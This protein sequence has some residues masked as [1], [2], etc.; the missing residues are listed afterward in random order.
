MLAE[1]FN[2]K[3]RRC[4]E[5]LESEVVREWLEGYPESTKISYLTNL[6]IFLE[7]AKLTPEKLRPVLDD[8]KLNLIENDV[9]VP[10]ADFICEEM[11]KRLEGFQVK[12]LEDRKNIVN[13]T[14]H[15]ILFEILTTREEINK[16]KREKIKI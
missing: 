3:G 15:E 7:Q 4:L 2:Q 16:L 14:L 13:K 1:R 8:F 6:Q 10:V 11:E 9:A 12:R 5:L